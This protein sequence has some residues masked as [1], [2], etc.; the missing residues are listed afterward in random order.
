MRSEAVSGKASRPS[1]RSA[2]GMFIVLA[3][4]AVVN[5]PVTLL[6]ARTL[7]PAGYGEFQLLNR[8]ALIAISVAQA[9]LPH[10]LSW[11][12][13]SAQT[14]YGKWRIYLFA[15]W[16]ATVGGLLVLVVAL[17]AEGFGL[18]DQPL[19][20][21]ITLAVYPLLNLVCAAIANAARGNLD[22]RSVGAIRLSQVFA[23]LLSVSYLALTTHLTLASA[24]VC[25][26]G[27]QAVGALFSGWVVWRSRM[28]STERNQAEIPQRT[29][30]AFARRVFLGHTIW[31]WNQY[32]DQV[33]VGLFLSTSALGVYA[34]AA[35]MTLALTLVSMP[36]ST[37]AQP[38]V[39]VTAPEAR[40]VVVFRMLATT[41]V[42][43]AAAALVLSLL[44]QVALVPVLGPEYGAAIP[45]IWVLGLGAILD[46]LNGCAHGCLVGLSAPSASSRNAIIGFGINVVGW[47][48][49]L[50]TLGVTGAALTSVLSYFCVAALMVES[51]RRRLGSF[52]RRQFVTGVAS[53]FGRVPK[54]LRSLVEK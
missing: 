1:S 43:V 21:W 22:I 37:T 44:A 9:G 10:A 42:L 27:S 30:W 24:V 29:I 17:I 7:D 35:G 36:L 39:Q 50:P 28:W 49:L 12:M 34:V 5:L 33:V 52:S 14:R 20:L 53:E 15:S 3:S 54:Q 18:V 11:A 4:V 47:A 41:I 46:A 40:P 13:T 31:S 19:A 23:W 26:T 2:A 48:T 25:L 45:L 51:L 38:V 32:L 8:T 6:L 16:T